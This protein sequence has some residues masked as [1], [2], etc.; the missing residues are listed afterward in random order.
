MLLEVQHRV[1][2]NDRIVCKH[3]AKDLHRL[4]QVTLT[5]ES[6]PKF[7]YFS[8]GLD[9]CGRLRSREMET[10]HKLI[11]LLLGSQECRMDIK[12]LG[13]QDSPEI[14]LVW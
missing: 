7:W 1:S 12:M 9:S 2:H 6:E 11:C 14:L 10:T 3:A 13:L 8:Q 4:L 5:F